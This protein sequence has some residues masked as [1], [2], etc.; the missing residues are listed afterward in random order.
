MG[1]SEPW[2]GA[3]QRRAC[4]RSDWRYRNKW[5]NRRAKERQKRVELARLGWPLTS[6][7]ST[8]CDANKLRRGERWVGKAAV[9]VGE[10]GGRGWFFPPRQW[11]AR[12][13]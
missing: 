5:R 8:S 13:P 7:L 9:R 3:A 4:H 11:S 1:K 6:M 12:A 2:A 10:A